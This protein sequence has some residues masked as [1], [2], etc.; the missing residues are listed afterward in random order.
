MSVI[1]HRTAEALTSRSWS[2]ATKARGDARPGNTDL[3]HDGIGFAE[4]HDAGTRFAVFKMGEVP[5]LECI[6]DQ[7]SIRVSLLIVGMISTWA[8]DHVFMSQT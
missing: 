7:V 6:V 4:D 2:S 5:R 8:E 1:L 3:W